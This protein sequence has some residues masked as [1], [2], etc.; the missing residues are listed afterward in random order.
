[1]KSRIK[2]DSL[3]GSGKQSPVTAIEPKLVALILCMGN[4]K[5]TLTLSQV[6]ELANDLIKNTETEIKLIEWKKKR[7]IYHNDSS[8]LGT[9]G[10]S[11]LREFLSRN[12]HLINKKTLSKYSID[13]SNFSNYLNFSD[14][15]DHIQRILIKSGIAIALERPVT[16]NQ[17]G[18]IVSD[19]KDG[20]G[21]NV[22]IKIT[23]PD[24]GLLL[25]ECGCNLSQEYDN[26]YGR[27]LYVTGKNDK[28]YH[29]ISTKY[30]HFT[31]IRVTLLDGNPL[32]CVVI[33]T[34]KTH[35]VLVEMGIDMDVLSDLDIQLGD[36]V[37]GRVSDEVLQLLKENCGDGKLFP[38]LP[39]CVFKGV[40]IPGYLTF[41]ESGGITATI[42]TNIFRRLDELAIYDTDRANGRIPFVLL[43]GHGSRFDIEFLE[44]I[45]DPSHRW[46]VCLGV[47][48][49][50]A[51]WQVADSSQQHGLFKMLLNMAKRKL[52]RKRMDSC[53]QDMHLV[54]TDIVP[55]VRECFMTAF[56]NVESNRRV[57]S[58]RGWAPY[59]RNLLLHPVI[60]A[61]ITEGM[62]EDE[63][64]N[65]LFPH[66][67][68]SHLHNY[69]Y[70][71]Q[72]NGAVSIVHARE[73]DIN[74]REINLDGGA[75]SKHV[76]CT[77][78]SD[79]DRQKARE[80]SQK[81]KQEGTTLKGRLAKIRKHMTSTKLTIEGRHYHM[82]KAV[83]DHAKSRRDDE[84]I[85]DSK[86]RRKEEF[87]YMV[88]CYNADRARE[89]NMSDNPKE[90]R[91]YN[92]IKSYLSP[93]KVKYVDLAWPSKRE[94]I[95]ILF[96][97]WS[98]RRRKQLVMERCVLEKFSNWVRDDTTKNATE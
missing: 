24:M 3:D 37:D 9:L 1:M 97:Q 41:S 62:L 45:N 56:G 13:R 71:V 59:N 4:I 69:H 22:P 49:G 64:M 66:E 32:M 51:L 30:N 87:E 79:Y 94:G 7:N 53:L 68:L 92:D 96:L 65:L 40:R 17:N 89:R 15:Y 61:T 52:F 93:L 34:G 80:R 19:E 84:D 23:R 27:E 63:K 39:S 12:D 67:R 5:R 78:V 18:D 38:G 74:Y 81:L 95:D 77:I 91:N 76:T 29:S 90:W 2:A 6:L 33:V 54:K 10:M 75:T 36:S 43:D 85:V 42:L 46:N 70:K 57:I 35:D 55:L 20:F 8:T 60:R 58:D 28:A 21:F 83:Y 14:M 86:K 72:G 44:Y 50:T 73:D 16:M 82:D 88:M 26:N 25:D 98:Q 11:F 47:P 48:Y 31:V